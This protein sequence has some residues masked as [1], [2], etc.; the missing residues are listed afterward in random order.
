LLRGK[1]PVDHEKEIEEEEK[2]TV[3]QLLELT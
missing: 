1:P 3:A 2:L